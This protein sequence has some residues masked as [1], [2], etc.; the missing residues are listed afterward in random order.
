[1]GQRPAAPTA[2]RPLAPA[3]PKPVSRP[4]VLPKRTSDADFEPTPILQLKAGNR[5]EHNRFGY[6][7]IIEISGE[8]TDLKAKIRFDDH[9]EKI[10][11]LKYAKIRKV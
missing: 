9:G 6:G 2:A 5:I 8:I 4:Q 3:Q 7:D 10:L 1:M 11:I